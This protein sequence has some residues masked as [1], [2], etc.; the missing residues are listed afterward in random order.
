MKAYYNA[1]KAGEVHYDNVNTDTDMWVHRLY[2]AWLLLLAR[3]S[4]NGLFIPIVN[5]DFSLPLRKGDQEKQCDFRI[6]QN[7]DLVINFF[8][9]IISKKVNI[10]IMFTMKYFH[11]TH[12]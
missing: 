2:R 12:P 7:I 3:I 11:Y 4:R 8:Q 1:V 9:V 10:A 6:S 5:I